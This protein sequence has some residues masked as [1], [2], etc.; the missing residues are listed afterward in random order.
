MSRMLRGDDLEP[1]TWRYA[2]IK[3]TTKHGDEEYVTYSVGEV[4][5]PNDF[6]G[7][8]EQ[9]MPGYTKE[10]R[11]FGET[12][13]E[14]LKNLMQMVADVT[15]CIEKGTH[16]DDAYCDSLPKKEIDWDEITKDAVPWEEVKARLEEKY[17]D[18][19]DDEEYIDPDDHLATD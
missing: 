1:G 9:N 16:V 7:W 19:E 11:P 17:G 13:E 5:A 10:E 14:L 15:D 4:F 3:Q 2:I 12:P 8:S 6:L 18:L